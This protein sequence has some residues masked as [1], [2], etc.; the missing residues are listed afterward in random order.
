MVDRTVAEIEQDG[1]RTVITYFPTNPVGTL[2][3]DGDAISY[4]YP[5]NQIIADFTDGLP[6]TLAVGDYE[7]TAL[8]TDDWDGELG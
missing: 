4:S 6:S 2:D 7:A 5:K 8:P 1:A 3:P